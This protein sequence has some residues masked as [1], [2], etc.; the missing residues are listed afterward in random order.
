[1]RKP[2]IPP[3]IEI[4]LMTGATLLAGSGVIGLMDDKLDIGFGG[5]DEDGSKDP[6]ANQY[7]GWDDDSWDKL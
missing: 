1:M 3:K 4:E 6:S 7:G 2:Y 5:V